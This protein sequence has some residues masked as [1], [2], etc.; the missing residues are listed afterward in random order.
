MIISQKTNRCFT[1]IYIIISYF[2]KFFHHAENRFF[3]HAL[4]YLQN[5]FLSLIQESQ[6]VIGTSSWP[7]YD[8][9]GGNLPRR[10][11]ILSHA[12]YWNVRVRHTDKQGIAEAEEKAIA[13]LSHIFA[14]DSK[15][16]RSIWCSW[17]NWETLVTARTTNVT[18]TAYSL[19]LTYV[20]RDMS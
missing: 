6:V 14:H 3:L 20:M 15:S 13:Y 2:R 10:E 12:A 16:L 17:N 19:D 7:L 18:A 8:Y 11:R 9:I 5:V 4:S 1:S